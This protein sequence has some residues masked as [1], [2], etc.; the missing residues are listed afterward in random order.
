VVLCTEFYAQLSTALYLEQ[1][2]MW[3]CNYQ[4]QLYGLPDFCDQIML[5][6]LTILT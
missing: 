6:L 1:G 4:L 2:I 3:Y 5:Y